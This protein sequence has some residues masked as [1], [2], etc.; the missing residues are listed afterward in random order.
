MIVSLA[1]SSAPI[2]FCVW[3]HCCSSLRTAS[4]LNHTASGGKER[5]T[6]GKKRM[7]WSRNKMC[8][9]AVVCAAASSLSWPADGS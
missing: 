1:G 4:A 5:L 9:L 3:Y 8:S 6:E 2:Y 7:E